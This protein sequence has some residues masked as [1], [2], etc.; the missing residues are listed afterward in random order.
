[1]KTTQQSKGARVKSAPPLRHTRATADA[2]FPW[3]RLATAAGTW[4]LNRRLMCLVVSLGICFPA[5]AAT[6][7]PTD[8][9]I[10]VTTKPVNSAWSLQTSQGA[11]SLAPG[12]PASPDMEVVSGR[13]SV[14]GEVLVAFRP[15]IGRGRADA[16]RNS[17]GAAEVSDSRKSGSGFGGYRRVWRWPK[18]SEPCHGIPTC[19]LPSPT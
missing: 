18:Q 2:I 7:K 16:V 1:M 4:T 6:D 10:R 19:V 3:S 12:G 13:P 11:V 14:R 17:I 15:G 5:V 9:G 8:V